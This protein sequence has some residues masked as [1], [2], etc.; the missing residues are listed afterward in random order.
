MSGYYKKF[1][2]QNP[3][4]FEDQHLATLRAYLDK[5][6]DARLVTRLKTL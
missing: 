1:L 4:A 6:I 3:K 2:E 5:S